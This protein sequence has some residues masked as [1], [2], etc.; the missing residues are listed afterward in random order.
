MEVISLAIS[1]LPVL[2]AA[3]KYKEAYRPTAIILSRASREKDLAKFHF[4]LNYELA[5]LYLIL[6]NL[7]DTLPNLTD[8]EREAFS[9]I[10]EPSWAAEAVDRAMDTKFGAAKD[11]F[12]DHLRKLLRTIDNLVSE[13]TNE[14]LGGNVTVCYYSV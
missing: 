3:A 13:R 5:S 2:V 9:N 1:I 11:L 10:H 8:E 14:L 6:K 4:D 12:L 7:A